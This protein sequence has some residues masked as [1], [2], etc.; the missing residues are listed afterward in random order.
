MFGLDTKS[1][2]IG[3][4]IGAIVVPRVMSAVAARKSVKA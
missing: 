3:V 4:V 1:I 2:V